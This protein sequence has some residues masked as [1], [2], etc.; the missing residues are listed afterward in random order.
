MIAVIF[1]VLPT[2]DGK[3]EYLSIAAS[4]KGRLTDIPGFISIERFQSLAD[5][6][7]LLSLSFWQDET[8]V[9]QWRNLEEH[10]AA[11]AKGRGSLFADY[12]IRVGS[13]S[14]DYSLCDRE[15]TPDDSKL[16]HNKAPETK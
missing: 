3:A 12:R 5:P 7:K 2:D 9:E 16:C 14:R 10:R 8:A 1:E 11:Q 4:L 15:Q 6:N 13:I